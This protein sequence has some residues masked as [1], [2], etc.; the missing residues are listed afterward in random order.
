MIQLFQYNPD[1]NEILTE[2][3]GTHLLSRDFGNKTGCK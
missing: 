3:F 1:D 2:N